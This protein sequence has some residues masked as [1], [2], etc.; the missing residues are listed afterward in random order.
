MFDVA[1]L[2]SRVT[3]GVIFVAHGAQ[4]MQNGLG[5]TTQMFT[6][7]GVPM[8][9][10]AA[11][12]TTA[13]ELLGGA[14]LIVGLLTRVAALAL[15][16]VTVG[17]VVFVHARNGVFVTDGGWELVGALAAGALLFLALGAGRISLDGIVHSMFRARAD[18]RA[19]DQEVAQVRP[20]PTPPTTNPTNVRTVQDPAGPSS[21]SEADQRAIDELTN[22]DQPRSNG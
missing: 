21:L 19:R 4:K 17:A 2:I 7:A 10:L 12:F 18:R 11:G 22:G 13:A 9:E 14:L 15:L 6:K 5:P 16:I 1:A 20:S 3:I 8:P